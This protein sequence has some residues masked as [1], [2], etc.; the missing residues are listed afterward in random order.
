MRPNKRHGTGTILDEPRRVLRSSTKQQSMVSQAS[1]P[2]VSNTRRKTRRLRAGADPW[3]PRRQK[4][5]VTPTAKAPRPPPPT[6]VTCRICVEEKP[7]DEFIK[8]FTK[9]R[10]RF[11][12]SPDVPIRCVKHLSKSPRS[13]RDPVC[14]ACIGSWMSAQLD[15]LG[16]R[17]VGTGCVE[18]GC[19]I[20]WDFEYIIKYFPLAALE[21]YNLGMLSVWERNQEHVLLT[22]MNESCGTIGMTDTGSAGYPQVECADCQMRICAVCKIPWHTT[23]SCADYAARHVNERMATDEMETLKQMQA[24][25][26][27]RCPNCYIVIE[28]DGGCNAMFCGGC[29]KY[30]DWSTASS[31]VPGMKSIPVESQLWK[32]SVHCEM[33][34][35]KA[36]LAGQGD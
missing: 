32:V 20:V 13:K 5:T 9:P 34:A 19:E 22:C 18:P 27:K 12:V 8:W 11:F 6:H 30:F 4:K 35:I 23:F 7:V 31:A 3:Y 17:K 28:K 24:K 25:D 21:D 2:T 15:T 29:N 33:D 14:K 26:G 16:A 1:K 10:R 36:G